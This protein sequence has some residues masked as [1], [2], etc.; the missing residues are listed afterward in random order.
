[1]FIS[2]TGLDHRTET[3]KELKLMIGRTGKCVECTFVRIGT[4]LHSCTRACRKGGIK[5]PS[6]VVGP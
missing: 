5:L 4:G 6:H 2:Y 1:M 3:L